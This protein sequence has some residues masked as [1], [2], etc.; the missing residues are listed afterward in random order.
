MEQAELFK[1]ISGLPPAAIQ[2]LVDYTA[3]LKT[4]YTDNPKAKSVVT[5]PDLLDEPFIGIWKDHKD[6]EDSTAWVRKTRQ[7][8]WR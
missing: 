2:Q 3:S 8:E 1:E 6:M 4:R 7:S 5:C